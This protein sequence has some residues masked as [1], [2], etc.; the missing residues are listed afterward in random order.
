[1][2]HSIFN[3]SLPRRTI[4]PV[5]S[6][7]PVVLAILLCFN[8]NV[9]ALSIEEEAQAGDVFLSHISRYR[10]F[11]K[12]DFT[13][14]YLNDIGGWLLRHIDNQ[15]FTFRFYII[16]DSSINAFAAPGGHIFFCS[17][18]ISASDNLDEMASVLAHELGHVTARHISNRIDQNMKLGIVTIVGVLAG[19]FMGGEVGQALVTGSMAANIQ[20]QLSFSRSDERQ[21]DQLGLNYM[22]A[23]GIDPEGFISIMSKIQKSQW[24]LSSQ[25]PSYL[26]TH[27]SGPERMATLESMMKREEGNKNVPEMQRLRTLFPVFKAIVLANSASSEVA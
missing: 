14:K 24:Y 26:M 13:D 18:L 9:H 7:L 12:T 8:V 16:K 17:G 23:A 4:R 25:I 19:I 1:M 20:A 11:V 10:S 3:M 5:S 6:F 22:E 27:P 15:P 21:A 2:N